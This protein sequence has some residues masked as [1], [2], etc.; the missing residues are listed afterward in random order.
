[1]IMGH[2]KI[3]FLLLSVFAAAAHAQ[4]AGTVTLRANQTSASGSMTPVL[5]WS[6][7]PVATSCR[8]S[9]GWSGDRAASGTQTQTRITANTN[10]TLTCSWSAGTATVQWTAPTT[11]TNGSALTNLAQFKVLYGTSSTSFTSY[12]LVDDSTLRTTTVAALTPGTWY[13]AVRAV[14]SSGQESDNSNVASKAVAGATAAGT[15][16]ITITPATPTLRTTSTTVYD[17]VRSGG[18]WV[19]GRTVGSI[20]IGRACL[21]SFRVNSTYYQVTRSDVRI[22]RT[23]RSTNLVARCATS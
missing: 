23:P 1:M 20:A 17:V 12:K 7:N 4:T 11:N 9:G 21:S 6:T 16:G 19:R 8:A 13:F 15:V 18:V 3:A 22:T 2:T 10:Y 5:T 14:N